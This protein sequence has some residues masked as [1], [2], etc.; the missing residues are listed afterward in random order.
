MTAV[1]VGGDHPL[2]GGGGTLVRS[3]P[4]LAMAQLPPLPA[5]PNQARLLL[6]GYAQPWPGALQL[7]DE[8]TGTSL[9]AVE[10]RGVLGILATA[11]SAGPRAVWDRGPGLDVTLHD[12]HLSSAEPLAVLAGSNRLAVETASGAWEVIGFAAAEL[13]APGRYRLSQLLR[14]LEGT[15]PSVGAAPIGSRVMLLD[16]RVATLGIEP[17]WLGETRALR[18]YAGSADLT[19]TTLALAVDP[20]PALPLPPV[21]LRARRAPGGDIALTWTRCS[22]ADGDGWG[23]AEAPLEHVPEAYHVAILDDGTARRVIETTLP[24]A[25]YSSADQ[26]LDFGSLPASF[27][28]TIAQRSPVLGAGHAATGEFHG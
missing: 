2:R 8:S 4:L 16:S 24:H 14:G 23:L 12:G 3:V 1:A 20:G 17:A 19:G 28:F 15:G 9:L 22:R 21:H 26:L 10:R 6:A 7:V 18:L 11:L 25:V 27:S 13:V 5:A